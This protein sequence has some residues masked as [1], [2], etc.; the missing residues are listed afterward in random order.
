MKYTKNIFVIIEN[1]LYELFIFITI[2]RVPIWTITVISIIEYNPFRLIL[3]IIRVC[4]SSIIIK[5]A[6]KLRRKLVL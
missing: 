1:R 3:Y 4:E 6:R 2:G 5:L